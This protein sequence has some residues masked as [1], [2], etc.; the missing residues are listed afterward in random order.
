MGKISE[1]IGKRSANVSGEVTVEV[2]SSKQQIRTPYSESQGDA[3][4]VRRRDQSRRSAAGAAA[5]CA[6]VFRAGE[7]AGR[8]VEGRRENDSRGLGPNGAITLIAQ[9]T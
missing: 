2:N 1:I 8:A 7:K 9:R 6:A 5:V 3:R 4:R